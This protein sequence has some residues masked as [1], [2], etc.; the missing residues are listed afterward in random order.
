M[1]IIITGAAGFIGSHLAE[2]L[3][4]LGH[5]VSGIDNFNAYYST[6]IKETTAKDLKDKGVEIKRL[7]LAEDSLDGE[8][9]EA[10]VIFHLAAQPG[11]SSDISFETYAKNNIT[12]TN[13]L[14][15]SAIKLQN[16]KLFVNIATSS[17]YGA[18]AT[19]DEDSAPRPISYYGVTKLAA[20]QLALSYFRNQG[21]PACSAR[22]FSVYGE[23]ERPEKIYPKLINSVLDQNYFVPFY[24]GSE[25]HV[26]SYTYVGDIVDGLILMMGNRDKV[27]GEIFNLGTEQAITTGDG[28]RIIEE[29]LGAKVKLSIK[30]KRLGDQQETR[31]NIKKAKNLLGYNPSTDP[32]VG[33]EKEV[34]WFKEK[35][36]Q[37]IPLYQ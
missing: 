37:K 36:W 2:R 8:L 16:L 18:Y 31:A 17:V 4:S 23:R 7:D 32:R 9:D 33:L 1:K 24:E 14:L 22:P 28:I 11:I 12:A 30:P 13:N 10:D 5:D 34:L 21:F 35:I 25:N 27:L 3:V 15:N 19:V 29:I 20:E 26:R 6:L